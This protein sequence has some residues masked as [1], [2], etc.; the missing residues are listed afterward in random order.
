MAYI[1]HPDHR[2]GNPAKSQW[3]ISEQAECNAF[4][5]S[6]QRDWL[7]EFQGWGLHIP[8]RRP[9]PLGTCV[10]RSRDSYIAKFVRSERDGDW[11]GY[12]ADYSRN[13]Q[14]RPSEAV[15]SD[16]E[17]SNIVSPAKIRKIGRLQ[18]CRL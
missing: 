3:I 14:D 17:R 5:V 8:R 10:G 13:H 2:N 6:E 9:T 1:V 15:L 11:H 16:W 12:P 4:T 7:S 18:P